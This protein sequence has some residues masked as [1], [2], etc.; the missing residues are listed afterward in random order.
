MTD[1]CV[2]LTKLGTR[3]RKNAITGSEHCYMHSLSDSERQ[4]HMSRMGRARQMQRR[5]KSEAAES[6]AGV[7]EGVTKQQILDV[8]VKLLDATFA[9]PGTAIDGEPDHA[10]RSSAAIVLLNCFPRSL[11]MTVADCRAILHDLLAGTRHEALAKI[12]PLEHYRT[13]RSEW[14]D[15]A[16]R[17][18]PLRGLYAKPCP[19]FLVGPGEDLAAILAAEAP[20]YEDWKVTQAQSETAVVVID[21]Q[22]QEH[23]V[24]K[25]VIGE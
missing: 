11:R 20:S 19:A 9:V 23:F 2:S 22:G 12:D 17:L 10:A 3:C 14:W 1:Q 15:A 24:Q 16:L 5:I 7:A 6:I 25:E 13:M 18:D 21:P 8:C 4:E